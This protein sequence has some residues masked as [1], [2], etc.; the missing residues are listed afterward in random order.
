MYLTKENEYNIEMENLTKNLIMKKKE[1]NDEMKINNKS[2]INV[3]YMRNLLIQQIDILM[4]LTNNMK[5]KID[6]IKK[7]E[8]GI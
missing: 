7:Y 5:M 2:E 3:N 6:L 4:K 1:Y 8:G